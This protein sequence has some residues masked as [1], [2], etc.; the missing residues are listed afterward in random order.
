MARK[1][2][3]VKRPTRRKTPVA[4]RRVQIIM[5]VPW[6][7]IQAAIRETGSRKEPLI[8]AWLYGLMMAHPKLEKAGENP[9]RD[10]NW[11]TP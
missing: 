9:D 3:N 1:T 7:T 11:L 10:T 8:A 6:W 2:N 5:R 4:L